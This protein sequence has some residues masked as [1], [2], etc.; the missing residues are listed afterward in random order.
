MPKGQKLSKKQ[1][2]ELFEFIKKVSRDLKAPLPSKVLITSDFNAA[3]ITVPRIGIFGRKVY[4]LLGLPLMYALSPDQFSAVLAHEIGHIS[5]RHG[6]SAKWA[7]QV[8][9]MW[10]R[11]LESQEAEGHKFAALYEKF[12]NWF[13]PYFSAYSFVLMREHE[14]EADSYAVKSVGAIPLGEALILLQTK[15]NEL[16]HGLWRELHEENLANETPSAKIFSRML[17][18]LSKIDRDRATKNLQNA[19]SIATTYDDTHPSLAERLKTIGYW[20]DTEMPELPQNS[21]NNAAE[22]FLGEASREFIQD[23]ESQWDE[24]LASEWDDRHSQFQEVQKRLDEIDSKSSEE[25]TA[26]EMLEKAHLIATKEGVEA[27]FPLVELTFEKFPENASANYNLGGTLLAKNDDKGLELLGSAAKLDPSFKYRSDELAFDYL[28]RKGR[29]NEAKN[30]ARSIDE[31]QEIFELAKLER[32]HAYPSE[33]FVAHEIPE[34]FTSIIPK[35][36]SFFEEIISIYLVKKVTVHFQEIPFHVLFV[37]LRDKTPFKHKKDLSHD[38]MLKIV[39]NRLGY[40]N[41]DFYALMSE[42][43]KARKPDFDKIPGALVY[44]KEKK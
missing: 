32:Q 5:G 1:A 29:I 17:T 22:R 25:L 4:L 3:V 43:M 23:F 7:Y 28:N 37:E 27:A 21:P 15:D 12:V 8:R 2:P 16:S 38:E 26:E 35:K 24:Q 39:V 9:E 33:N 34:E 10:V 44:R 36:L 18:S 42:G 11:L 20:A 41:I 19:V 14:K 31:Q 40:G 13:V 6:G 30:Y